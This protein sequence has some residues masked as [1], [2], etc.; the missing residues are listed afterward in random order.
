MLRRGTDF[1][2]SPESQPV[3]RH[4][5]LQVQRQLNSIRRGGVAAWRGRASG[6]GSHI[7]PDGNLS[8][9]L[10]L[11]LCANNSLISLSS[12]PKFPTPF[13]GFISSF[14]FWLQSKIRVFW[15]FCFVFFSPFLQAVSPSGYQFP[16]H[17]SLARKLPPGL[18]PKS[19]GAACLLSEPCRFL[20]N[21]HFLEGPPGG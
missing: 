2:Q 3:T 5:P 13:I 6:L 10:Q 12:S 4:F 21:S 9:S 1:S 7:I 14:H 17:P 11:S 20:R 8:P 18:T 19:W 15:G 16:K